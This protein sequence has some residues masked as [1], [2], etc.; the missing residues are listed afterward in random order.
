MS[1]WRNSSARQASRSISPPTAAGYD[2]RVKRQ[3]VF[4]LAC[5]ACA[6][7]AGGCRS[8]QHAAEGPDVTATI[9]EQLVI[10][11]TVVGAIAALPALVEFLVERRKRRER[12]ALSLEDVPVASIVA[13]A[14]GLQDL[15]A[16][17]A[18]LIDRARHPAD[19]ADVRVGNEILVIG[20]NLSGKKTL[21]HTIALQAGLDRLI[22]IH[23]PR[24]ADA[25]AKAKSLIARYRGRRV[26][27]LLP[28]VDLAFCDDDVDVATELDALIEATSDLPNVLVVGTAHSLVA[29][30]PLDDAFGIKLLMPGAQVS[31]RTG[32]PPTG[33]ARRYLELIA[34]EC[35]A[36]MLHAGV[37]LDDMDQAGL[38]SRL[39]EVAVNPAEIQDILSLCQT[40]AIYRH[41]RCEVAGVLVGPQ[42]LET[43]VGRV[44][45]GQAASGDAA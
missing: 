5:V 42:Q 21:A 34:A 18:D 38:S 6:C 45:V 9:G 32:R 26:M 1:E 15:L 17:I 7:L 23:N 20:D 28:R 35:I 30:S 4:T 36:N 25:L 31:Y 27:L 33:P 3:L 8:G 10:L 11:G 24:N 40:L 29:D 19:Y 43:A 14:A 37:Q 44:V 39:L 12:L 22:T 41:K 13:H 16:G 2:A